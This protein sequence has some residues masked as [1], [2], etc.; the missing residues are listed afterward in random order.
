MWIER[1]SIEPL[2]K[3]P[4]P[5]VSVALSAGAQLV[6]ESTRAL[7]REKGARSQ[8]LLLFGTH[9]ERSRLSPCRVAAHL[10]PKLNNPGGMT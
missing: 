8:A 2:A 3:L 1:S 9:C 10:P 4:L 7:T 5:V 6:A